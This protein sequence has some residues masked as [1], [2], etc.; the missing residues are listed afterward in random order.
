M[1]LLGKVVGSSSYFNLVLT[2]IHACSA[3]SFGFVFKGLTDEIRKDYST[4]KELAKHTRL[5]PRR[6]HHT[7]KEFINTVQ[8]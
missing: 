3:V 7:L 6:R 2:Q 4:M 5:S 1:C 8:E